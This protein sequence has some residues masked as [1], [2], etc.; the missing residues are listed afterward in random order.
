MEKQKNKEVV[1]KQDCFAWLSKTK[2][3]A[4]SE[5]KCESCSFYQHYKEVKDY[6]KYLP[7]DFKRQK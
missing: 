2:C 3:N 4:L 5:K 1:D 6:N 7:K